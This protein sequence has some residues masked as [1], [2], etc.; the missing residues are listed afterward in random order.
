MPS[1]QFAGIYG[2]CRVC[3]SA[4]AACDMQEQASSWALGS[5]HLRF[6]TAAVFGPSSKSYYAVVQQA[7]V[8]GSNTQ[9]LLSWPAATSSGSLEQLAR[10]NVLAGNVHSLHPIPVKATSTR[11]V[12][13]EDSSSSSSVALVYSDGRVAFGAE[14]SQELS[15][16]RP[17]GCRV[18]S[19]TTDADTLAVV[20][21]L[22]GTG[23]Q[24][25][26][27]Y[28]LQVGSRAL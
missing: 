22:K 23:S 25:I 11:T 14:D 15:T 9:T 10:R 3:C 16:I 19:A 28:D 4:E 26:E 2:Q 1:R 6:V 21:T 8:S 20:C 17:A 5:Q 13:S 7:S 27:L 12:E 24:Q 18:L